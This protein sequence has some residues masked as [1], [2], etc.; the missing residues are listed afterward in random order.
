MSTPCLSFLFLATALAAQT[1]A[2]PTSP[3]SEFNN[4]SAAWERGEYPAALRGFERLLKG[5]AAATYHERI[6][7]ITGELYRTR[8]LTTDGRSVRISPTGK[9]IA[10]EKGSGVSAWTVIV[11][12]DGS[13]PADSVA[14]TGLIFDD[15]RGQVA[16]LRASRLVLRGLATRAERVFGD[17]SLAI[18]SPSY[19]PDGALLFIGKRAG[20]NATHLWS[21]NPGTL[22]AA[23]LTTDDA[24]RADLQVLAGGRAVLFALGRDPF[25]AGGRGGGGG[26]G[27]AGG[28]GTGG[29][30]HVLRDLGSGIEVRVTGTSFSASADGSVL[31]FLES[32]GTET[33]VNVLTLGGMGPTTVVRTTDRIDA[34]AVSP[35]GRTVAY[36]RMPREDWELYLVDADGKNERRLTHE[37]QH[38]LLPRWVNATTL[39]GMIGEARHRRSYVYDVNARTRTRL[40]HNN[41]IRTVAPEYEWVVS[42]DGGRVAIVAERDGDTVSPERGVYVTDLRAKVTRDELLARLSSQL[43]TELAL[44]AEASRRFGPVAQMIRPVTESVSKDRI[45]RYARDLFDF[46]SKHISQPG[47]ARAIAYLDS[48]YRS[49]GYQPRLQ[50][51]EPRPGQRTANVVAT[52]RGT[53]TPEIVYVVGSHFD[54]RAEGP[55]ADD[56]SS[57]TTML[58]ETARVL[59]EH[60]LPATVVFVS[61]TGEEAGLL[62]SREFVRRV[63]DSLRVVG[64]MN[65][66]MM[67]WSNDQRLDN[68]IRYSNPG[69]RDIQHGAALQFS[70]LITYDALY[71]K[72]TDAAALFDQYGDIIGGFG[73]YPILGNPHYHQPHDALETI[74]FE[75]VAENT[76]ANVAAM[77]MLAMVPSRPTGLV[78]ERSGTGVSLRWNANP[79]QDIKDYLVRWIDRSG[80]PHTARATAPKMAISVLSA[81]ATVMVKAVNTRGLD[82]WDWAR[83]TVP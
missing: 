27:G 47:N 15:A 69:I 66:D 19:R 71:Y 46:D 57:G 24:L 75:Q 64:A 8:E 40:F 37:I 76:K 60:P 67:G 17:S 81:G 20:E 30:E 13:Q 11:S 74:N 28:G 38:D 2:V 63:K 32:R 78:A 70:R 29:R 1:P 39:L 56:N 14:G 12:A 6:A 34:P 23:R 80:Q 61:F 68:T 22:S 65:N 5:P 49:F 18:A 16:F 43:A 59:A 4:A 21:L 44:R 52:L 7:L 36:Q 79:E 48:V 82:G 41:S 51:F 26:R 83:V 45:Y 73:S 42:P 58:L 9:W 53:V 33:L 50:W 77:M 10:Y 54:S 55:G 72:S 35:D 31:A 25:V 62:G 3:E